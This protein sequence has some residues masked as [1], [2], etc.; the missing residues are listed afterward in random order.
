MDAPSRASGPVLPGARQRATPDEQ[1][2]RLRVDVAKRL[3]GVCADLPSD[4]FDALV[5]DICAMKLRWS[6]DARAQPTRAD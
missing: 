2:A 5:E 4:E 6:L 1:L 3:R